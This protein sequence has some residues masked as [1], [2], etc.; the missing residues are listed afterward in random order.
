[1]ERWATARQLAAAK[2]PGLPA[3]RQGVR[4]YAKKSRWQ[5]R[6]IVGRGGVRLE[7]SIHC[8][9]AEQQMRWWNQASPSLATTTTITTPPG[10]SAAN[11][12]DQAT[13]RR[14]HDIVVELERR[15]VAG[16]SAM[17]VYAEISRERDVSVNSVRH[18]WAITKTTPRE[19]WLELLLPKQRERRLGL[20][21]KNPALRDFVIGCVAA[22]M[23]ESRIVRESV[24]HFPQFDPARGAIRRFLES[25]KERNGHLLIPRDRTRLS[26]GDAAGAF[27]APNQLLEID[28]SPADVICNDGRR[29]RIGVAIDV[30]TR[31]MVIG[32]FRTANSE[33]TL[34]LLR[35]WILKYGAP[36]RVRTD[37]GPEFTS[38]R[39]QTALRDL[40]IEQE[41]APPY[42]G[43]RKPFVERAIGTIQQWLESRPGF[44]GHS[45]AQRQE[46]EGEEG[47]ANRKKVREKTI[48]LADS[49]DELAA[50]LSDF[51]KEY[52]NRSHRG[53]RGSTPAEVLAG[54]HGARRMVNPR[55]LDLTL[56][57]GG[58]RTVTNKGIE[59]EG[60][61]YWADELIPFHGQRVSVR[62][63]E[64]FGELV[65][66]SISP[67]AFVC[68][69][70]NFDRMGIGRQAA[71]MAAREAKTQVERIR[72]AEIR[73][74]KNKIKPA[75]VADE[76]ARR[77][78]EG[79]PD[80]VAEVVGT[81]AQRTPKILAAEMAAHALDDSP[82]DG[83]ARPKG[84]RVAA[85]L[86]LSEEQQK[87][88]AHDLEM[89]A[90]AK[91]A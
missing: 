26:L 90:D 1:M 29:Y 79:R 42:R 2:L 88:V 73:R 56:A 54:W 31:V 91:V 35:Q 77:R 22:H 86:I 62:H 43:D 37:N 87:Q 8:L 3:S 82:S 28:F 55:A 14:K 60:A 39:V 17:A 6:I 59:F 89:L 83:P 41:F 46:R 67:P 70:N 38:E 30:F 5:S 4:E 81:I 76:I 75:L 18:W 69:A 32:L 15:L 44:L 80:S 49:P 72:R 65:V 16:H 7:Y 36:A 19:L 66:Y 11:A 24:K 27:T 74:L 47:F 58:E 12:K 52:L 25:W 9:S 13:A 71:S 85:D 53:L 48:R 51:L 45:V 68:V 61:R 10:F 34:S 21:E 64:D 23:R 40:G 78:A 84:R 20:I 57:D 33:A 50:Q 63:S